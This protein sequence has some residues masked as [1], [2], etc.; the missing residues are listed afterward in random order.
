MSLCSASRKMDSIIPPTK[1]GHIPRKLESNF[2]SFTTDEW[3]NWILIYSVYFLKGVV[4][5][6][7]YD[8]WCLLVDS[9]SIF[10]QF[11]VTKDHIDQAHILLVEFC[12]LFEILYGT[13]SCTPNMHMSCH[14]KECLIDFVLFRPSG[15]FCMS[16]IM[17]FLNK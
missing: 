9:C 11:I 6:P 16:I 4:G 12:K 8:C 2:S 14:L 13:E 10:C 5:E 3:K 15:A 7:H 1:I 17:V